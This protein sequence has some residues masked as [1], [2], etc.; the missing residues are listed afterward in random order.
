[1]AS[2]ETLQAKDLAGQSVLVR[3]D[4]E[5]DV[6][7]HDAVPTLAFACE[8][9]ARVVIATHCGLGRDAAPP[10]DAIA[11]RLGDMLSR[12][13]GKLEDWRGEG[14]QRA[15]SHLADGDILLLENL[16]YEA[17]ETGGDETLA[18]ALGRL[19]DIYCNEAFGLAHQVRAS[20]VGVAKRTKRTVAGITFARELAMLDV[21]LREPRSPALA[22][23]GGKISKDKML[24]AEEI[25]ERV[26]HAFIAGQ[27]ALPFLMV[28]R[29]LH[30]H[31]AV[32]DETLVIAERM[33]ATARRL[34]HSVHT[35]VDY[36]V[37]ERQ[38]FERLSRGEDVV[39]PA[40][41]NLAENQL[42]SDFVI[43][44]IGEATRWGWSDWLGPAR[45]IF[46]HGPL[47]ICEI[48]QFCQGSKFLANAVANRT[49]PTVH[50][51]VVCGAS[52]VSA[53]RRIGFATD[54]IRHLTHAG[55]ASLH[56]FAARPLPAV[57][58]LSRLSESKPKPC[59]VLIPLDG[60]ERDLVSLRAAAEKTARNAE[61]ILLHVRPGPDHE[62]YPG[63][64][65]ILNE[66]EK[67]QY[68]LESE[69]VFARA[70]GILAE[71]GKLSLQQLA[72][73][74]KPVVMILRYARRM[75]ADVIVWVAA[76][77]FADL[78]TRRMLEQTPGAV[79]IV[80]AQ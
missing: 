36:T 70:N 7:L 13:V 4:A 74:G 44:D 41:Q 78:R 72:V 50:R 55:N 45:T 59:R 77:T 24:L 48:D 73:Q 11:A 40:L 63:I 51:T 79:L 42:Q 76:G 25:F 69:R 10:M 20:T 21:M 43:G 12:P 49:W 46:W 35:P 16:A 58:V 53:L 75:E 39:A 64:M 30:S 9:G 38:A 28:N 2:I 19:A 52:L 32:T 60:S 68:R 66:S 65:E 61:I 29:R 27:L 47:G 6:K 15:V 56:Y 80:R 17:G 1:M 67:L 33:L 54:R 37:V 23:L 62:Q 8:A 14:A 31:A 26:D 34:K 57:E 71:F 3:V 22:F 5:D 18:D